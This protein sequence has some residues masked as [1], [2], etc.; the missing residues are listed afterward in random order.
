MFITFELLKKFGAC[1]EGLK[2][3]Q[4]FY[5]NG[6][7]MIDI[8]QD[9]HISKEMLHWGKKTLTY[10]PEEL[11]AYNKSCDIVNS[12]K[13]WYSSKI[14][15][16]EYIVRSKEVSSSKHIFHGNDITNS[17]DIVRSE[18]VENSK[19]IFDSLMIEEC[20]KVVAGKN[21]S[22]SVNV[23]ESNM[24]IK[25]RNIIGSDNIFN[26]SEIFKCFNTSYSH[27]CQNCKNIKHCMFCKDLENVEYCIFN[28]QIDKDQYDYFV[29][30]YDKYIKELLNFVLE[31]PE[32]LV[33]EK[34]I[35]YT[36]KI[37]VWFLSLAPKFWKWVVTLPNFDS[38]ILYNITLLPEILQNN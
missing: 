10:T 1:E 32:E 16:S 3:I 11:E 21:I 30:Q 14:Y 27:F 31:W 37:N 24:V 20:E 29:K 13:I 12:D 9:S 6:A 36:R 15:D 28:Q 7:E 19:Q 5:P 2:Y 17:I 8:I 18:N 35:S 22:F 26:S 33:E 38:M 4:S 23:C 34:T 25:S